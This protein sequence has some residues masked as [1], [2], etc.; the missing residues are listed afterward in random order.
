MTNG[1][2]TYSTT[3]A[4]NTALFPEGMNPS[5]V[6]DSAR[7][8]QADLRAWYETAEWIDFGDVPTYVSATSFTVPTDLTATRYAAGRRIR[9]VGTTP[10][11]LYGTIATSTYS[12]P[13]T[14]VGV[15]M[16]SGT[17]DNTLSTVSAGIH[18]ASNNALPI[19]TT[20]TVKDTNFT[21]QDDGDITKQARFQASGITT[22]TT[23]TYTLQDSSD[24]LVGRATTDTLTNKTLTSPAIT[25]PTIT[26][27]TTA[28][29]INASGTNTITKTSS[30]AGSQILIAR[31]AASAVF[32]GV[33]IN[34]NPSSDTAKAAIIDSTN[35]GSDNIPINI[36][37]STAA[38]SGQ[39]RASF[40]AAGGF[41]VNSPS[42]STAVG[43]VNITGNF[44]Q[45]GVPLANTPLGASTSLSSTSTTLTV[46][47]TTYSEYLLE[48]VATSTAGTDDFKIEAS[49]DSGGSYATSTYNLNLVTGTTVT[50]LTTKLTNAAPPTNFHASIRLVQGT[51]SI[52]MK[53][54]V[55]SAAGGTGVG[56]FNMFGT[57]SS[58]LAAAANR[59][60]ISSL[61]GQTISG[62]V[63]L[64][65]LVRR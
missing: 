5:S 9:M 1:I 12:A 32:T 19:S 7:Q 65:P 28:A 14:T 26:G 44:T 45:N 24:T 13:N 18:T 54:F 15:T 20:V 35:D 41:T 4:S 22:A 56:T 53:M 60:K 21:I 58:A 30:G 27:T 3:A 47:F 34:L 37:T 2:K 55:Q 16:D 59:I 49:S 10:F 40:P 43:D 36:Y 61:T 52:P 50:N 31:N 46:D 29:A 25:T 39:L 38:A 63:I 11:T 42:G 23:R 17:L 8:V 51:T 33:S 57:I 62:T 64:T 6:N 48:F